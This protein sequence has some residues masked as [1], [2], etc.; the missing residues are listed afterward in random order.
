[1]SERPE[2]LPLVERCRHADSQ[3][4]ELAEHINQSLIP[5]LT[6]LRQSSKVLDSEVVTDQEMLDRMQDV[7]SSADHAAW[8]QSTLDALLESI[9]QEAREALNL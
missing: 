6:S 1:M 3:A 4:R 8:L 2:D 5:Q 9:E 7:L